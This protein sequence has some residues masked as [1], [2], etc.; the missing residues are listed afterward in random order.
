METRKAFDAIH[1]K[2][3]A[4]PAKTVLESFFDEQ[5]F[6]NFWLRYTRDDELFSVVN[7]RGQLVLNRGRA[8]GHIT[9]LLVTD[10]YTADEGT[11][12]NA[13]P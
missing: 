11:V 13:I 6:G 8:D 4:D 5:A 2:L 3:T 9:V 1:A 7:D 12:L 10:L